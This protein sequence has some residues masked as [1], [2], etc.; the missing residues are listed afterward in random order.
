MSETNEATEPTPNQA[1]A[2]A[3]E[4]NQSV[5]GLGESYRENYA[6]LK[7][8]AEDLRKAQ[9]VDVDELLPKVEMASKAHSYC[10]TRIEE[11][12]KVLDTIFGKDE[13]R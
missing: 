2:L 9:E 6:L 3:S 1:G 5:Q 11:A 13:A 8:V 12:Q 10:R 7:G 4:P